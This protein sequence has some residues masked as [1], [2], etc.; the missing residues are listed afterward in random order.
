MTFVLPD[1]RLEASRRAQ[2]AY[3]QMTTSAARMAVS[4][5]FLISCLVPAA[6]I[7]LWWIASRLNWLPEQVLPGPSAVLRT[8]ADLWSSG[9]L[10]RNLARTS[11]W[12]LAGFAIGAALG[13]LLGAILGMSRR[14]EELFYPA[15]RAMAYVPLLGW[16]PLWLMLLGP[17]DALKL[18][19]VAQASLIPVVS[20]ALAGIKGVPPALLEMGQVLRLSRA[21]RLR[22]IILPAALPSLWRGVRLGLTKGWQAL[23]AIEVVVGTAGLGHMIMNARNVYRLDLMFVAVIT[24]GIVGYALDRILAIVERRA[25]RLT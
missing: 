19:L 16:L 21:Q 2:L 17:G 20:R 1:S 13:M 5:R 10:P 9:E 15:L 25:L 18:V 6:V 8:C 23:I 11:G 4:S 3:A 22:R 7:A 12:L 14:A 24:V